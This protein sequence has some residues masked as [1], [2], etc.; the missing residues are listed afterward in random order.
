MPFH[1]SSPHVF[2][3]SEVVHELQDFVECRDTVG[4]HVRF[5]EPKKNIK[6]SAKKK[7]V[8]PRRLG[9]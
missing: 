7:G 9:P 6:I 4:G 3:L 8:A 5:L 1:R 2:G